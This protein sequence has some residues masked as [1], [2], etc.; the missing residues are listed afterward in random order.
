MSETPTPSP[1]TR[2]TTAV[3][4]SVYGPV[5]HVRPDAFPQLIRFPVFLLQCLF[6][7]DEQSGLTLRGIHA[8]EWMPGCII[9]PTW[10]SCLCAGRQTAAATGCQLWQRFAA[11]SRTTCN[12]W[13]RHATLRTLHAYSRRVRGF[14]AEAHD[15][16]EGTPCDCRRRLQCSTWCRGHRH[17]DCSIPSELCLHAKLC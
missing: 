5:N 13:V 8:H 10:V 15:S 3:T 12:L 17:A 7:C 4:R 6:R 14:K 2:C 1:S 9:W 16:G 11:R